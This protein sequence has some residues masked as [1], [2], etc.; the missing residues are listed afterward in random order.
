MFVLSAHPRFISHWM[1]EL[2]ACQV[3]VFVIFKQSVIQRKKFTN[4]LEFNTAAF[5][6]L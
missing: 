4:S 6:I 2:N 5:Q 1:E 3:D